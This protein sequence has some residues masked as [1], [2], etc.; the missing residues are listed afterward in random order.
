MRLKTEEI[1]WHGGTRHCPDDS[2]ETYIMETSQYWALNTCWK[3]QDKE[4]EKEW[5]KE[6]ENGKEQ[7]WLAQKY[8]V[9]KQ[10]GGQIIVCEDSV[11]PQSGNCSMI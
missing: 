3:D 6:K 4:R 8:N 7:A 1:G 2:D 5:K 11:L 9:G 10:I